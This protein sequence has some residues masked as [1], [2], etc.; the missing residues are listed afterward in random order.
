MSGCT[1]ELLRSISFKD[2]PEEVV[3]ELSNTTRSFVVE[4]LDLKTT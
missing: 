4:L 1:L 2:N 3:A